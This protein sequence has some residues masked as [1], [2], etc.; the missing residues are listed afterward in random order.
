MKLRKGWGVSCDVGEAKEALENAA[1][2]TMSCD[3]G[4]APEG[5]DNEL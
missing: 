5:L 3:I 1:L 2:Q 4:E